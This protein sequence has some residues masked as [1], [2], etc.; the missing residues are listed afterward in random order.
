M[1]QTELFTDLFE[2]EAQSLGKALLAL[3]AVGYFAF[4]E[5]ESTLFRRDDVKYAI[6]AYLPQG[7]DR[8]IIASRA[9]QRLAKSLIVNGLHLNS[10]K[11][12]VQL[13][14]G[15]EAKLKALSE[16]FAASLASILCAAHIHSLTITLHV[17]KNMALV[18]VYVLRKRE[19]RRG[20]T[21][22]S[23][24]RSWWSGGTQN[25]VMETLVEHLQR[26]F[27]ASPFAQAIDEDTIASGDLLRCLSVET[28]LKLTVPRVVEAAQL[29][30]RAALNRRPP[31]MF[32][33]TGIVTG[34]DLRELL[35][36]LSEDMESRLAWSDWF[37]PPPSSTSSQ[38]LSPRGQKE[39]LGTSNAE[40]KLTDAGTSDSDVENGIF[41]YPAGSTAILPDGFS[42][43][44]RTQ[45]DRAVLESFFG[46]Q[47]EEDSE[48][49]AARE[50]EQRR[51][52]LAREQSA[53]FFHELIH[54]ASFNEIC[55]AHATE[56]LEDTKKSLTD[57]RRVGSYDAMTDSA[58]MIHVITSLENYRLRLLDRDFN[59]PLYLQ[60]FCQET[61]RATCGSP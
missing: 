24:L 2:E 9:N 55:I 36:G 31:H 58:K 42:S 30:V 60:L 35:D 39:S 18:L 29:A 21:V 8:G 15:R 50:E 11:E 53:S 44:M 54:S 51:E 10:V 47:S 52:Q 23:K 37:T 22:V 59:V 7:Y 38:L 13:A 26:Q 28:L 32:S 1:S 12:Q 33:V 46:P 25:L 6:D 34:G 3:T 41:N 49:R 16:L 43:S 48:V 57:L 56:V 40:N 5:N 20:G 45:R 19:A 27:E 4:Q 14:V 61:V 17:V